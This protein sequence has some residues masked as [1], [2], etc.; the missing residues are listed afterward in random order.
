[1]FEPAE[2][3]FCCRESCPTTE[4]HESRIILRASSRSRPLSHLAPTIS[5]S[6]VRA[7][8]KLRL[9]FSWIQTL[10]TDVIQVSLWKP[11]AAV[12]AVGIWTYDTS[13]EEW[14][15]PGCFTSFCLWAAGSAWNSVNQW[16]RSR[17]S[18]V[19]SI[20]SRKQS[21]ASEPGRILLVLIAVYKH[22]LHF[23]S[24]CL[25][26]WLQIFTDHWFIFCS[27]SSNH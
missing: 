19:N 20:R 8:Q 6:H 9:R 21:S 10:D 22:K 15:E 11:P 4:I 3:R 25:Q 12:S 13:S 14:S 18:K 1:M 16:A 26:P 7:L 24:V 17:M 27:P 23:L 5:Q 2:C